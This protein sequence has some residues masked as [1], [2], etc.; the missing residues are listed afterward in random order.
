MSQQLRLLRGAG[1]IEDR[2]QGQHIHY[3]LKDEEVRAWLD[4]VLGPA[5]GE[6]PS[7]AQHKRAIACPCPKCN[8]DGEPIEVEYE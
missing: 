2:R 8:A 1:L 6:L 7:L 3:W 4:A 5:S